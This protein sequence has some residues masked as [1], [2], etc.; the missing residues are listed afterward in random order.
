VEQEETR[1]KDPVQKE[2]H[3]SRR[4]CRVPKRW[5]GEVFDLASD[6]QEQVPTRYEEA[7]ADTNV[8]M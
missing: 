6:H 8:D 1:P 5:T 4:V 2:S 7:I 3:H